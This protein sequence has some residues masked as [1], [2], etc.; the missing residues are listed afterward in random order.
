MARKV[1]ARKVK[2]ATRKQP[3]QSGRFWQQ[4]KTGL[5]YCGYGLSVVVTLVGLGWLGEHAWQTLDQPIAGVQVSGELQQLSAADIEQHVSDLLEPTYLQLDL[6]AIRQRL[7][8]H[9]WV[10]RGVVSRQWPDQ[11]VLRVSERQVFARWGND[12]LITAEGVRFQPAVLPAE[13]MLQLAGPE[14]SEAELLSWYPRLTEALAAIGLSIERLAK[15]Q[16]G[17]WTVG[18]QQGFVLQLGRDDL[19]VKI[20]RL[21]PIYNQILAPHSARIAAI[22]LRYTNGLAVRWQTGE[23]TITNMTLTTAAPALLTKGHDAVI[24]PL[25]SL[26]DRDR[27]ATCRV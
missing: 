17:S 6:D 1:M 3:V 5:R 10:A 18:L 23:N 9:P 22:D 20:A 14:H 19:L 11:I 21:Q 27:D 16:R 4:L 24:P 2:G 8:A 7:E 13:A 12:E 25:Y 15:N 26:L